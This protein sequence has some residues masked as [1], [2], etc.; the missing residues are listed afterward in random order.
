MSFLALLT[1]ELRSRMRRE[2]TVW[3]M[4]VY[5]ALLGLAGWLVLQTANVPATS[6]TLSMV[7]GILYYVLAMLQLFLII[8]ITPA[9]TATAVNGEKERQTFDLLLCSQLTGLGLIAGKLLAGMVNALLLIASSVPLFS[10]LLFFGGVS[11]T[12]L[13]AV[14][15]IYIVTT[16]FIGN[17]GLFSSVIIKRPAISTALTYVITL[18]WLG[19]PLAIS[20]LWYPLTRR[21]PTSSELFFI[22]AWNPFAAV[23]SLD[24][25]TGSSMLLRISNTLSLPLWIGYT[26]IDLAI[27][28][29]FFIVSAALARPYFPKIAPAPIKGKKEMHKGVEVTA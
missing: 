4:V 28:I 20:T 26:V 3:L 27:A 7:G 14:L 9:F 25:S 1:K 6:N 16:L 21:S 5:I 12:Q 10:L 13:L 8:F 2:R 22:L 15:L 11:P 17:L 19:F 24:P 18:F 29:I 23:V